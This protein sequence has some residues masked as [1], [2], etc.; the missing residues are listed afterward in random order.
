MP[1]VIPHWIL[2]KPHF[3]FPFATEGIIVTT[4]II[5]IWDVDYIL[6]YQCKFPDFDNS[7]VAMYEKLDNR[8]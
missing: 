5:W 4:N 8:K 6:L 2:D 1:Q 3:K 7:T